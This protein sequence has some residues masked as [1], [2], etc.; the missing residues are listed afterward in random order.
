MGRWSVDNAPRFTASS[1]TCFANVVRFDNFQ[2]LQHHR[3]SQ[4][5]VANHGQMVISAIVYSSPRRRV[6]SNCL[7]STSTGNSFMGEAINGVLNFYRRIMIEMT[8]TAAE[9]RRA[10]P[11]SQNNQLRVS[12]RLAESLHGRNGQTIRQINKNCARLKNPNRR[13]V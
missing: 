9:E 1:A 5:H 8:E 12:V 11:C 3:H 4:H 7:S 2:K 6:V 10:A 13:V